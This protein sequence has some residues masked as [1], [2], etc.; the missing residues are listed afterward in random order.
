[1]EIYHL[2][3][4]TLPADEQAAEQFIAAA[5]AFRLQKQGMNSQ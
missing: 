2:A 3:K 4:L 1:M 5:N